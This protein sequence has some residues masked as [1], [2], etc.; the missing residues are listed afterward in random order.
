[1]TPAE[2]G[3]PEEIALFH[4]APAGDQDAA[5]LPVPRDGIW[6]ITPREV[7]SDGCNPALAEG[8]RAGAMA[9][10]PGSERRIAWGGVARPE[11]IGFLNGSG[12]PMAWQR[13]DAQSFEG[14]LLDATRPE[15]TVTADMRL[16]FHSPTQIDVASRLD[17]R[18]LMGGI[19]EAQ[20]AAMG[21]SGCRITMYFDLKHA[22]D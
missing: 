21:L 4:P 18:S 16:T 15:A 22:R 10:T 20:L 11:P 2:L 9:A 5:G 8:I 7:T 1:M 17:L 3:I 14:R 12:A 19:A 6:A 13:T